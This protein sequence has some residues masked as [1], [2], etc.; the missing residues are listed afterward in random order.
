MVKE[1]QKCLVFRKSEK[2][3]FL[4]L[5]HLQESSILSVVQDVLLNQSTAILAL[6]HDMVSQSPQPA[7]L[8]LPNVLL[9][10]GDGDDH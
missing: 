2:I 4:I 8:R 10:D 7:P 1:A 6:F 5:W 9:G 3:C